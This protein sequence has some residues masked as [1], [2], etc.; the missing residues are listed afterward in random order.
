[1]QKFKQQHDHE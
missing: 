1:M